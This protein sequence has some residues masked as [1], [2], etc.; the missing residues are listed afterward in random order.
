M[1][2]DDLQNADAYLSLYPGFAAGF[3]AL[4]GT[5]LATL[6]VGR[7]TLDGDRLLLIIGEDPGKGREGARLEAHRRYIDLQYVISGQEEMGWR[8]ISDCQS[9]A[10][11][12]SEERD[13]LFFADA[14]LS[15]CEVA[16]GKFTVFFPQDAHAPLGG[17]GTIRKAVVK[18]AVEW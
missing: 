1:I 7:H 17:R 4:R 15:W 6:P 9:I 18:V 10:E 2:L 3:A 8:P 14:S 13:I 11:T 12:Y 5:N 16:P